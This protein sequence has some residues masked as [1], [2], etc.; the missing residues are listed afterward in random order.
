MDVISLSKAKEALNKPIPESNYKSYQEVSTQTKGYLNEVPNFKRYENNPI[1]RG[2]DVPWIVNANS[3]LYW[4]HVIEMESILGANALDKFYMYYS[5]D[6]AVAN[7]AIGLATAPH[8]LGPWTDRGQIYQ[9]TVNGG[10]ETETPSILYNEETGRFHL[11]Y[12]QIGIGRMQSTV[13]ATSPNGYDQWERYGLVIDVPEYE[14]P[15]DAHTGYARVYRMGRTWVAHHLM[16]GGGTYHLGISYSEDGFTWQTD[17][18]PIVGFAD[19]LPTKFQRRIE[20]HHSYPFV[21]RGEMW[22]V[23]N[24]S[25]H[26]SGAGSSQK[27]IYVGKMRT[28]RKLYNLQKVL[29]PGEVGTWDNF[30]M[31]QPCVIEYESKLYMYYNASDTDGYGAFGIAIGDA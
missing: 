18:R 6:H 7:G 21:Y 15:G 10:R 4:Q 19:L 31:K 26:V 14:F 1:L 30:A 17:P 2:K 9:D 23:F 13:L 3:A 16:G 25:P 29:S 8:P 22:L 20:F 27:D 28:P 24:V 11:Y 12:Q 5:S